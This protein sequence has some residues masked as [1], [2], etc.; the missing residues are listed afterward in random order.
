MTVIDEKHLRS[1]C[2]QAIMNAGSSERSAQVLADATVEA[3]R[4]G[5]RAVGLGHL[6]DY[7]DGYRQCRISSDTISEVHRPTPALFDV[8]A[9]GGIAQE[10]FVGAAEELSQAAR[11]YGLSALWVRNSFTCG[12]LGFYPRRL[13][14]DGMVSIAVANSPALM[15]LGGGGLIRSYTRNEP[16]CLWS[17]PTSRLAHG[18]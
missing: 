18:N 4:V 11:E 15:S 2:R 3:E 7:L 9:R 8:N 13:A 12:E 5:N 10:A 14:R 16:A 17:S 1:L 6:F